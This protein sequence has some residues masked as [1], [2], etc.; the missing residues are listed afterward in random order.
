MLRAQVIERDTSSVFTKQDRIQSVRKQD[1]VTFLQKNLNTPAV[2]VTDTLPSKE[3]Q[4]GLEAYTKYAAESDLKAEITYESADSLRFYMQDKRIILYGKA[5]INYTDIRL[6][7]AEIGVHWPTQEVNAEPFID[8]LGNKKD[9]PVFYEGSETYYSE[10]M[11]YNFKSKRAYIHGVVTEQDQAIMHGDDINLTPE[12]ELYIQNARY[13]TCNL[14]RPHFHIRANRVKVMP[15]KRALTGPF[16]M[17]IAEVPV[18]PLGFLFGLFPQPKRRTSGILVPRYGEERLRG[19]FLQG[20]GYYFA[21]NDYMDLNVTADIYTKGSFG[22]RMNWKYLKRYAFNGHMNIRYTFSQGS[23]FTNG[24]SRDFWVEWQHAPTSRRNS[25][26]SVSAN[27]GTSSFN[28][29]NFQGLNNN[30]RA[31]V[32]SNLNYSKTIGGTPFNFTLGIRHRQNIQRNDINIAIPDF[33]WNMQRIY[34]LQKILKNTRSPLAK[35]TLSHSMTLRNE[36]MNRTQAGGADPVPFFANLSTIFREGRNGARHSVPISFSLPVLKYLVLTPSVSYTELWYA[37]ELKHRYDPISNQVQSEEV[38]GFSRAGYYSLSSGVSTRLYGTLFLKKLGRLHAIRHLMTP[39]IALN[40]QPDFAHARYGVHQKIET[41]SG[42]R[43]VS[44]Y[45]GFLYGTTPRGEALSASITLNNQFEMKVR[46]QADSLDTEEAS[47]KKITLLDNL[48]LST[49]YNFLAES[50]HLSNIN[51]N[52]RTNLFKQALFISVGA[53][54]DPYLWQQIGERW[55]RIDKYAWQANQGL[56][57]L[58][59]VN[60]S[61]GLTLRS[62]KGGQDKNENTQRSDRDIPTLSYK[63]FDIPWNLSTNY[64][65]S[66]RRSGRDP[67]E[68][69]QSMTFRGSVTLTPNTSINFNS[70]YD[71]TNKMFTQTGLNFRRDLHCW[72]IVGSWV[73]FG[74]FTSYDITFRAKAAILQ[75]LKISKRRTFADSFQGSTGGGAGGNIGF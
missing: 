22:A 35:L 8:S 63:N 73:P 18:L 54:L 61:S 32:S 57:T 69:I 24:G 28:N 44:K 52:T 39:S 67:F 68:V 9:T 48:S 40:Y 15:G 42:T 29:N 25:R 7:A 64:N 46:E 16:H 23:F 4:E 38:S 60:L 3:E 55:Q 66:L 5:E 36:I 37:K 1:S 47:Y 65:L 62:N 21:I 71:F 19:F 49:G 2:S 50:F 43:E 53:V 12:K 10:N 17:R 6:T 33:S 26:F 74:R 14:E 59:S 11:R 45:D 31:E 13:T 58:S 75:D 70:G 27:F 56:G 34:P 20:G 41:S 51:I 72:E 30:I